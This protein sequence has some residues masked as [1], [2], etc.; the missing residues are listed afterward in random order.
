MGILTRSAQDRELPRGVN[1]QV[2]DMRGVPGTSFVGIECFIPNNHLGSNHV[3]SKS[4]TKIKL[5]SLL[6]TFFLSGTA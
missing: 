4:K 2:I 3:W 5:M 1:F 6:I